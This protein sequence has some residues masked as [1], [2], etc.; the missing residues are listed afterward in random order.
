MS[1]Y[2]CVSGAIF[3]F[4]VL[5][6]LWAMSSNRL[7]RPAYVLAEMDGVV[8]IRH[9]SLSRLF[10]G[11][12]TFV[13]KQNISRIQVS[14]E[15]LTLFTDANDSVEIWLSDRYLRSNAS[16]AQLLFPRAEFVNKPF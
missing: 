1:V 10:A 8:G 5:A 9:N 3:G 4:Y 7:N 12:T 11:F 2:L 14:Q 16:Y 6:N 13:S 15:C